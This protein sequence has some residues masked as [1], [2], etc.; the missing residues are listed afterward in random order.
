MNAIADGIIIIINST[1]RPEPCGYAVLLL[2]I[3]NGIEGTYRR[4][5]SLTL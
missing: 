3:V 5:S 4:T 2:I 1:P